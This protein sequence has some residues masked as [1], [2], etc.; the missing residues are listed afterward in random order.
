MDSCA[1]SIFAYVCNFVLIICSLY[2]RIININNNNNIMHFVISKTS[3][4]YVS[5]NLHFVHT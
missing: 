1:V 4:M 3:Y 2:N 5:R